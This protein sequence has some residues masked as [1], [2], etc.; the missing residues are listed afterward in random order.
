MYV[1]GI[2]M[3]G[4]PLHVYCKESVHWFDGSLTVKVILR[5]L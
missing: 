1:E 2:A 3:Q 4:Q 5:T